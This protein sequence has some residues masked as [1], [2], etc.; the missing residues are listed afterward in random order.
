M[1]TTGVK[2]PNGK[3]QAIADLSYLDSQIKKM[4][5]WDK[6]KLLKAASYLHTVGGPKDLEL[7]EA[8]ALAIIACLSMQTS[9]W[10]DLVTVLREFATIQWERDQKIFE[11]ISDPISTLCEESA[12]GYEGDF[13]FGNIDFIRGDY[14]RGIRE[15]AESISPRNA[16]SLV[17]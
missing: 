2:D 13:Q 14:F 17:D 1:I 8:K 3:P 12:V 5:N 9:G 15:L 10:Q 16:I 4:Q 7:R 6:F 11:V